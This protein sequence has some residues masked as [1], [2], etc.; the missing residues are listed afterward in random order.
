V[1]LPLH[2]IA[3]QLLASDKVLMGDAQSDRKTVIAGWISIVLVFACIG[4]L[5]VSWLGGS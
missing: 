3:L 1:L 5:T 4:A 2:V